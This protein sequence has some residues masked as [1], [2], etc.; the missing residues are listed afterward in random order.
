[1]NNP[2]REPARDRFGSHEQFVDLNEA[3]QQLLQETHPGQHG[4]RQIAL[5]KT[6]HTTLALFAFD[7]GG[8]MPLHRAHGTVIV[9]VLQG[10]LRLTTPEKTHSLTAGQVLVLAPDV[11]HDVTADQP[12]QMLLTV[13]LIPQ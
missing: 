11:P 9:Q 5:Y 7:A 12:A 3:A 13:S 8:H 4:H 1:M 2:T 6:N 10:S